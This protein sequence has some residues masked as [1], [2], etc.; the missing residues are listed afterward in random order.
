MANFATFAAAETRAY[1]KVADKTWVNAFACKQ[2]VSGLFA[3]RLQRF[4]T[5][6]LI[7]AGTDVGAFAEVTDDA[8]V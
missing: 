2:I 7:A 1:A 6:A 5:P 3:V 4:M 8:A